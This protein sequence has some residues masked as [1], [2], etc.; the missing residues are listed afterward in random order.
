MIRK[1]DSSVIKQIAAGEVIQRPL[2]VVKELIE[3]SIDAGSEKIVLKI[4]NGGFSVIRI[5]DDG[6]GIGRDDLINACQRHYTSKIKDFSDLM[7][8]STFGFRGEALFSM[9]CC[10]HVSITSKTSNDTKGYF[11]KYEDG[12][13]DGKIEPTYA[14]N[15]TIIEIRDLFYKDQI[16][17]QEKSKANDE[18]KKIKD[19]ILDYSVVYPHIAFIFYSGDREMYRSFGNSTYENVLRNIYSCDDP[20]SFFQLNFEIQFKDKTG[21]AELFLSTPG[22]SKAPKHSAIFINGRL[23]TN[24]RLSHSIENVYS[25]FLA[26][27]CHP[28]FFCVLTIPSDLIDVNIH[29]SK[30]EVVI[31]EESNVILQV[32]LQVKQALQEKSNQRG[33]EVLKSKSTKTSLKKLP[34]NQTTFSFPDG[35]LQLTS[36]KETNNQPQNV[37]N[38]EIDNFD[39]S[40]DALIE[41][42]ISLPSDNDIEQ[43]KEVDDQDIED[44]D[45]ENNEKDDENN[46]KDE[47]NYEKDDVIDLNFHINESEKEQFEEERPKLLKNFLSSEDD[48]TNL[49]IVK[50]KIFAPP[51]DILEKPKKT[52]QKKSG[53]ISIFDDLKYDPTLKNKNLQTLEQVLTQP[54]ISIPRQFRVVDLTSIKNMK[55]KVNA[56]Y[57]QELSTFIRNSEF[58]G[59]IGLKAVLYQND[60]N[61]YAFNLYSLLKDFLFQNLLYYFANY[62]QQRLS[63]PINI[64]QFIQIISNEDSSDSDFD[65][66]PFA[67]MLDDYFAI[68]I[69][70]GVLYS[71]PRALSGYSPSL[72]TLPLFLYQ[73]T[74]SFDWEDEDDCLEGLLN[75]LSSLYSVCP[76]D[77]DDPNLMKRLQN[78]IA[79]TILPLLKTDEY[80]PSIELKNSQSFC[81]I[82]YNYI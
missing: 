31:D 82:A 51:R 52:R 2:N 20:D 26:R 16:R 34:P 27:G 28:F 70:D 42:P 12:E 74:H 17:I 4:E 69:K 56:N 18:R 6:C 61:L 46:E 78:E 29:P 41:D 7:S 44:K 76:E 10:A 63:P 67:A 40:K 49:D 35:K 48:E 32:S 47:E 33:V 14:I 9:S 68:S 58:V 60:S 79:T 50:P 75:A 1:L 72:S 25:D 8:I 64:K 81:E 23:I 11:A 5:E 73:I 77:D 39:E 36:Q 43:N 30:K 13:L 38:E 19:L 15:G 37:Q 54:Q 45:D 3:N 65:F 80:K 71:L 24:K 62:T 55:E 66:A 57:D 53:N 22:N 59:F 21:T